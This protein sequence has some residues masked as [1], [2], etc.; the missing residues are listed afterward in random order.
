MLKDLDIRTDESGAQRVFSVA[1]IKQ[2]GQKVFFPRAI[3]TGL[4]MNMKENRVRGILPVDD[5]LEATDHVY[6]VGIDR[7]IEYN[8]MEITL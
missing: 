4:R 8:G 2:D 6:P 3:A 7:F 5:K 1:F